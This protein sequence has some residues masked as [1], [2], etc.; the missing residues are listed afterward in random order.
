MTARFRDTAFGLIVRFLSGNKFFRYPDE[1][2]L[3][4]WEKSLPR[5]SPSTSSPS[6]EQ[7]EADPSTKESDTQDLDSRHRSA[8]HVV[9]DGQDVCL[10]DWYGPDDPEVS[11]PNWFHATKT[12][13][14]TQESRIPK[15]GLAAGKLWLLFKCTY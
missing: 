4:L 15:I 8:N 12:T 3:S 14:L 11:A 7:A 10:V 1:I 9:E 13:F 6:Q 2:D 5:G